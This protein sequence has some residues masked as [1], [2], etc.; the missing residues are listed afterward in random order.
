VRVRLLSAAFRLVGIVAF[1][2]AAS[3]EAITDGDGIT[4]IVDLLG[5]YV[6]QGGLQANGFV[7]LV[8]LSYDNPTNAI[9]VKEL[10]GVDAVLAAMKMHSDMLEVQE[11][12]CRLLSV[13]ATKDPQ[14]K[15]IIGSE[16][17]LSIVLAAIST[18]RPSPQLVA[19]AFNVITAAVEREHSAQLAILKLHG[20]EEIVKAMGS[21]PFEELVQQNGCC[22]LGAVAEGNERS[23]EVVVGKGGLQLVQIA[24][25]VFPESERLINQG[26]WAKQILETPQERG[27]WLFW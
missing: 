26:E 16:K 22:A 18:H 14:I 10:G 27:S 12:G 3:R 1:V 8:G 13:I 11:N 17:A 15:Q 24:L 7:G 21:H 25:K 9:E 2:D 6:E 23:R 19:N 4:L 20:V 5:A